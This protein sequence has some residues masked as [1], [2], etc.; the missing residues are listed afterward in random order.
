MAA[1]WTVEGVLAKMVDV[2]EGMRSLS[3][4]LCLPEARDGNAAVVVRHEPCFL[5]SAVS[6]GS[7]TLVSEF[8][9][10]PS[11][12][13]LALYEHHSAIVI[14]PTYSQLRAAA[15]Q[16]DPSIFLV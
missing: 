7:S 12:F 10:L 9:A 1:E 6:S 13:P 15:Q 2:N 8:L 4:Y 11:D 5:P 16:S 3:S 14:H